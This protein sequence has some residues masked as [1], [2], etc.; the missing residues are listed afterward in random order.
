VLS[1]LKEEVEK[2]NESIFKRIFGKK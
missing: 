2:S 1:K